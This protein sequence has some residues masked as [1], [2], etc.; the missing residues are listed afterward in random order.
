LDDG[1]E[2][3]FINFSV[4]LA[5]LPHLS[6]TV[7]TAMVKPSSSTIRSIASASKS[8]PSFASSPSLP[9]FLPST[10][11]SL[12]TA[13]PL[14]SSHLVLASAVLSRAPLLLPT[15]TPL[16]QTYYAY[17]RRLHRSISKPLSASTDWFFK[18]GSTAEKNFVE[19]DKR[20]EKETGME[21]EEAAYEMGR[22]G[23]EGE[24]VRR[25][26]KEGEQSLERKMER[27]VYLLVKNGA[28]AWEFREYIFPRIHRDGGVRMLTRVVF[29]NVAQSA[30][31][32]DESLLEA[33]QR[34]LVEST[35]PNMDVWAPG[36]V[37]AG[38]LQYTLTKE[39]ASQ[40]K[41]KKEASVRPFPVFPV[42]N[43]S[44]NFV[45]GLLHAPPYRS[46]PGSPN[47]QRH[48]VRMVDQG[49]SEGEGRELVLEC[50]RASALR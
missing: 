43:R 18:K 45:A 20:V 19:F 12:A 4:F 28:A 27:T 37:P 34:D 36:R 40:H 39:Q 22:S 25:G 29:C 1:R 10:S 13:V 5:L 38:A 17:Q 7:F 35:G 30:P 46:R 24:L 8:R 47:A 3:R 32:A 42:D 11:R 41:G 9:S 31:K 50:R 21:A 48:N 23:L 15:L 14:P 33:V 6:T 2:R 49:G 44:L 16:E 26:A